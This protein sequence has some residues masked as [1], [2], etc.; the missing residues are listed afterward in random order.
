M[1]TSQQTNGTTNVISFPKGLETF[2]FD[3]SPE[4][5]SKIMNDELVSSPELNA[6]LKRLTKTLLADRP[7]KSVAL[8]HEDVLA[9]IADPVKAAECAKDW[10]IALLKDLNDNPEFKVTP[11]VFAELKQIAE[12]LGLHNQQQ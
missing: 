1:I 3:S 11:R 2:P 4:E 12:I 5:V 6:E 10:P 9:N 7:V 8:L